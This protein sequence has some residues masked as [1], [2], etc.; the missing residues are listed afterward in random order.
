VSTKSR[1][2]Q[3]STELR[4]LLASL[5]L[6]GAFGLTILGS[7]NQL[8]TAAIGRARGAD[9]STSFSKPILGHV[10][11]SSKGALRP[12]IG[13]PGSA[14]LGEA[15]DLKIKLSRAWISPG[16]DY[17]LAESSDPD[18]GGLLLV[19]L[20]NGLNSIEAI[21]G[22]PQGADLV[23]LSPTGSAAA[24]Y[25]REGK[26]V[27]LL[28]GLPNFNSQLKTNPSPSSLNLKQSYAAVGSGVPAFQEGP[29]SQVR[30]IN[31]PQLPDVV[32]SLGVSDDATAVL[33]G[34]SESENG[35]IYLLTLGGELRNVSFVGRA[36]AMAF[37][38]RST[39]VLVAD[40]KNTEVFLLRDVTGAAARTTLVNREQ[41]ISEP[42]TVEASE[43]NKRIFI[44]NSGGNE[45][46][47]LELES[48]VIRGISAPSGTLT[49]CRLKGDG[50]FRLTDFSGNL[51][52]LLDGGQ[53]EPRVVF[54]PYA[55]PSGPFISG[56]PAPDRGS[57]HRIHVRDVK[58]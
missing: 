19:R 2:F 17:A 42:V 26:K 23:A 53:T 22:I 32:E 57:P 34:C 4:V 43:D 55:S 45:I 21:P 29:S 44:V 3:F 13:I 1:D 5:F 48:G 7:D 16:Q 18:S 36:A 49:L 41:G 15:L 14:S 52:W 58:H 39:N 20:E 37:L 35:A 56:L 27:L 46:L 38:A 40:S 24:L 12:L 31:V 11:D 54:V 8:R 9:P 28:E 51:L 33:L 25:F 10:F 30:Q 47:V 6:F 50:V